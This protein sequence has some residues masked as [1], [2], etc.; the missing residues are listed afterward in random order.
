[1][2]WRSGET[3]ET[4]WVGRAGFA[5]ASEEATPDRVCVTRVEASVLRC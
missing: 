1:M 4:M 2:P 3:V 5:Q